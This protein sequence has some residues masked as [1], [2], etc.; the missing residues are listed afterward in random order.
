V[1]FPVDIKSLQ[2]LEGQLPRRA[3][4]LRFHPTK[5]RPAQLRNSLRSKRRLVGAQ[6]SSPASGTHFFAMPFA[7]AR[8]YLTDEDVFKAVS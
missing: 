3:Q 1:L 4:L 5:A 7:E 8:G 6:T 2:V